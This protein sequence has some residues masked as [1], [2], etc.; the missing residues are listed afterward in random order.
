[1]GPGP[2]R[3]D[4][5]GDARLSAY[6]R[7]LIQ[8]K[9]RQLCQHPGFG[10][11]DQPD[12]E[13]DLTLAL[14]RKLHLYDPRRGASEDTFAARVIDSAAKMIL[15]AS[16][17]AKRAP[18]RRGRSLDAGGGNVVSEVDGDRRRGDSPSQLSELELQEAMASALA[19]LTP[20][21]AEVARRLGERPVAAV[22]RE[23]GVSRRQVNGVVAALR[24]RFIQAGLGPN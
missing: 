1:M 18:G 20:I 23:L 21:Q 17:R 15:R 6:A 14:L 22:A 24:E 16:L 13:Q 11:S 2:A 4:R 7:S 12:L 10:F 8:L 5:G 19:E 3:P 9:A